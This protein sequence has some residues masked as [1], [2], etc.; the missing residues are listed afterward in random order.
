LKSLKTVKHYPQSKKEGIEMPLNMLSPAGPAFELQ[1]SRDAMVAGFVDDEITSLIIDALEFKMTIGETPL[2]QLA[3]VL[4]LV[5]VRPPGANRISGMNSIVRTLG[6]PANLAKLLG[7]LKGALLDANENDRATA[8]RSIRGRMHCLYGW[9]GQTLLLT[10]L[11]TPGLGTVLPIDD[12]DEFLG[13][14]PA[15]WDLSIHV[16][17]PN[18]RATPF[19][20]GKDYEPDIL[21]E[22]PHSHPFDFVSHISKGEFRQSIYRQNDEPEAEQFGRYVGTSLEK[23]DGVW[24]PHR[25]RE[26]ATLTTIEHRV[27]LKSGDSY[28]MPYDAIHD[29][30]VSRSVSLSEPT[31]SLFLPCEAIVKPRVFMAP[32]LADYQ[33]ENPSLKDRGFALSPEVWMQ[34]LDALIAYLDGSS[35]KLELGNILGCNEEY[36]FM[37]V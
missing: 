33:D 9:G 1:K 4:E 10:S 2:Q 12:M 28:F 14:P 11:P 30:E 32:A 15:E 5:R 29:V 7:F 8:L 31:V 6:K 35:A 18:P 34:K 22:P 3:Q 37:H 16:W 20:S 24:P 27:L 26:A 25:T 36:G 23:V 19:L 21:V 17:Q 13:Y